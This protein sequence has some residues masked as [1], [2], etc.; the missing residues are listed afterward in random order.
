M[1]ICAGEAIGVE[2]IGVEALGGTSWGVGCF[3]TDKPLTQV[4]KRFK[5]IRGNQFNPGRRTSESSIPG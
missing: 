4:E 3:L 2:S 1:G 5:V